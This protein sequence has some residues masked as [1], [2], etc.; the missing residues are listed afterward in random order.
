[1]TAPGIYPDVSEAEYHAEKESD[2]PLLSASLCKI[3]HNE[4]PLHTWCA[5]PRLNPNYVSEEKEIFDIGTVAHALMLQGLE[6]AHI[7]DYPDWR[8]AASRVCRESAR[9]AGKVPIL[10]K[11]WERVSLMVSAGEIQIA[12]HKEAS[13]AFTDGT[14][15]S[16]LLWI[17]AATDGTP[18]HCKARLDWL[19]ND[20]LRIFDYKSTGTSV[21][22]E[23][24]SRFA[25]SQNWDIQSC[26]YRRGVK[27]LFNLDADFFFVAQEDREPYALTI[28]G[29]PPPF[30][31]SGDI[32]VQRA[33]DTWAACLESGNWPAYSDRIIYPDLP[34][35]EEA[36][37]IE[38]ELRTS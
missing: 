31:W 32:K 30:L 1:M 29:M 10:T 36:R 38:M 9:A 19:K 21:N 14:A 3:L 37:M 18:V 25:I 22:P 23:T 2:R 8:T 4:S 34:A 28:A 24:I 33:I 17:D 26:F 11:H 27:K 35:W 16:V 12:A 15:E 20:H 13:D 5:S 7:C 6:I